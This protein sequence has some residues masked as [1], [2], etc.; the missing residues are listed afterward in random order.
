MFTRLLLAGVTAPRQALALLKETADPPTTFEDI[1][2]YMRAYSHQGNVED[3]LDVRCFCRLSFVVLLPATAKGMIVL[4]F[5]F[6][7][8]AACA[9][10]VAPCRPSHELEENHAASHHS[11]SYLQPKRR[12]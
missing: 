7:F 5:T 12:A 3:A 11:S 4:S 8:A 2:A 10:G 6:P 9:D 1:A